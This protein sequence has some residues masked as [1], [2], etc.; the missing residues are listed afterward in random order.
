[1]KYRTDEA[2]RNAALARYS[3]KQ[4][5]SIIC[6]LCGKDMRERSFRPHIICCKGM[7]SP[8]LVMLKKLSDAL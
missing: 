8:M 4:V 5:L 2:F 3:N 7:K 1:M 6:D